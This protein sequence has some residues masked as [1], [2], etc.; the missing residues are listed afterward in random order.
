VSK[1]LNFDPRDV[2][3][4]RVDHDMPAVPPGQLHP[5]ALRARFGKNLAWRPEVE[6]EP[7]FSSRTPAK[8]AV[9]IPIVMRGIDAA[10]PTILL[11]R[12]AAHMSTHSGQIAFPGGKVDPEDADMQATALRE[13]QEEVGLHPRHV[14]VLGELPLY[15]TGTAFWV[16]PVVALI[17]PGFDLTPNLDEVDDVFEVPLSFLMNPAHHRRHNVDWQGTQRQ[18]FSMPYLEHKQSPDGEMQIHERYIW[19]A[20]AAMLR[21]FYHFLAAS[22]NA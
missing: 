21:N 7:S 13:A 20:T 3:V 4:W 16:T 22:P 19:G 6:R 5:D 8:A 15:V 9:L 14:Q 2:P 1:P 17:T 11:T 10:E 18:W 12:R